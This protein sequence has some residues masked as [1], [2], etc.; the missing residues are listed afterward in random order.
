M[1]LL[2]STAKRSKTMWPFTV[3]ELLAAMAVFVVL[4]GVLFQFIGGAQDVWPRSKSNATIYENARVAMDLIARDLQGAVASDFPGQEIPFYYDS[5]NDQPTM[6]SATNLTIGGSRAKLSEVTYTTN[7]DNEL[8]REVACDIGSANEWDFY[9]KPSNWYSNDR[10]Q[11]SCDTAVVIDGVRSASIT[12]YADYGEMPSAGTTTN[13][14]VLPNYARI[15]LT[16]VDPNL[17]E[18]DVPQSEIDKS[19]RTFTKTVYIRSGK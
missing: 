10:T 11:T 18:D 19:K 13:T 1:P 4:M 12:C 5:D 14:T 7:S 3:I 9:G 17:L 6:V 2:P 16:L 15:S 8:V